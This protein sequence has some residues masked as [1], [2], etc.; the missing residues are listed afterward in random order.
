LTVGCGGGPHFLIRVSRADP[1]QV[2]GEVLNRP[3][4]WRRCW[5]VGTGFPRD[6]TVS[7]GQC[8]EVHLR[9]DSGWVTKVTPVDCPAAG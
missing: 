9:A 7:A 1:S 5:A 3:S 4:P 2:C 8:I 6:V